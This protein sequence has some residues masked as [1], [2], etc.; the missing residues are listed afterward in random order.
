MICNTFI[1]EFGRDKVYQFLPHEEDEH[2]R[3]QIA[4]TIRGRTFG[5]PDMDFWDIANDFMMG[6]RFRSSRVGQQ[7][8]YDQLKERYK[9]G[10]IKVIGRITPKGRVDFRTPKSFEN[11]EEEDVLVL[12]E[13]E[14]VP[15]T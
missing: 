12:F 7:E 3:R 1:H 2:E 8:N 11:F 9:T 6:W 13:R 10:D 5:L 14:E 4:Q 15:A